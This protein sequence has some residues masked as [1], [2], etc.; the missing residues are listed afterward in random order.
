MTAL[1]DKPARLAR[2]GRSAPFVAA[3][4]SAV[5]ILALGGCG[6][7]FDTT[8][9]Y[10]RQ[11]SEYGLFAHPPSLQQP[12][13]GVVPYDVNS[14]LFSDYTLKF[15]FVRLPSGTQAVYHESAGF[16]FPVGTI[17]AK[18]FAMPADLRRPD[19]DLRLI[20]TR[21]LRRD[22]DG[23][24]GLPYVWND[25]QTEATLAL[26]G[27][28]RDL[29]WTHLDGRRR[30]NNYI[31]PN[32]NQCKGC[33]RQSG[34][35]Q[36]IGLK[37]RHL[38][39]DFAYPDGRADQPAAGSENQLQ[40]WTRRGLLR[41]APPPESAPRLAVWDDPDNATLDQRARAWLE[42]NCA[43]C[44]QPGSPAQNAG[45]DLLASQTDPL[46][47]G[48]YK[49]PVAAGRGAGGR[50]YGIVPGKPDESILVYRIASTHPQVMMPEL[51]KRLVH[52]EGVALVRQWVAQMPE[53]PRSGARRLA[54]CGP[55]CRLSVIPPW[56]SAM[57]NQVVWFDIPVRDLDRAI[58]F[59]SALLGQPVQRE[60]SP[61]KAVGVLPHA[62]HEVGGCLFVDDE[63]PPSPHG[64]LLYLN[65]QGRLDEALAA[66]GEHGGQV[67]RPKH[68]I[69]PY[70][71]RAVIL[72]SEGN[73][74]ALHSM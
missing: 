53:P 13:E 25:E 31:I 45:L 28:T 66:A 10:P 37:A 3:V 9:P 8:T 21:I 44:H 48:V 47:Y 42:I 40:F 36:P 18:T 59:Y 20:E 73:R 35:M 26:A 1:P 55:Y 11:L 27:G 5:S 57:P 7:S 60:E 6:R 50:R 12:A 65:C 68:S 62:D 67:V 46:R 33:H 72:D 63:N 29:A 23:W 70:G 41:G 17:V 74:I 52:D 14:A 61:G 16:D 22:P 71:Y 15:R 4:A 64:P 69:G 39:R 19:E 32:A 38:N 54:A 43:H 56:S 49:P 58:R 2:R 51:G 34:D 30:T 24:I